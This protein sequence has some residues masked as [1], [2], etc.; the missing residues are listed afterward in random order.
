[1]L[2]EENE[3]FSKEEEFSGIFQRFYENLFT[4]SAPA[5]EKIDDLLTAVHPLV[6]DKM[7]RSLERGFAIEEIKRVVFFIYSDKSPGLDGM[8]ALFYQQH[9]DI[10]GPLVSIVVLDCMNEK[11]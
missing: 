9:C 11:T 3:W 4:S 10:M 7:A 2:N 6:T 1:M 5:V 8:N